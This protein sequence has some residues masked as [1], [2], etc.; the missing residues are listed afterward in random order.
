MSSEAKEAYSPGLEGVIAGET[1]ISRV[2]PTAGL[3]Y[4]GFDIQDLASGANFEEVAWL[5][6]HG[7]VPRMSELGN[8]TRQLVEERSLPQPVLN[9][10][11]LM[12]PAAHPMDSLRTG[13]SMLG[14][15]D[16][17]LNDLSHEANL[18]KAIRL[19]ARVASLVIDGWRIAHNQELQPP[20]SSLTHAGNFLYQLAGEV[21]DLWCME[22]ID[23]VLVLYADHDFNASTFAARVTASTEAD[24]YAAVTTALG[25][26]KGPLHGGA[27]E[28][29][30]KM[31]RAIGAPER[32]EDWAKEKLAHKEK[33]TGFGHRVYEKGDARVP[34]MREMARQLGE[35][36]GQERWFEICTRMEEVM[37]REKGLYA[38]LDL[39]AAPVLYLLGI[40][41][42]LNTA[43]VACSRV[44]GW[45]AH[46]IEQQEHNRLI[47][48]RSC[49]VGA[50]PRNYQ[51]AIKK[52]A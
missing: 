18:R 4:R 47:R 29:S 11:R 6:L 43:V 1:A 46:I 24:M 41:R 9:M 34:V 51:R 14:A 12:P 23:T 21:P 49:Y 25:T 39:Y 17:E 7:Q 52:A 13:V 15:F 45:C 22:I 33:I 16:P 30:M 48:P 38:N 44:A 5:L 8:F 28:A 50:A 2:D 20:K 32:A 10:L 31:L 42:E 26:L 19:I 36:F 3:M 37:Q 27:N 35:R 40:P